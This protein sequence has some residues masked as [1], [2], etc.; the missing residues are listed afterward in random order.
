MCVCFGL[1]ERHRTEVCIMKRNHFDTQTAELYQSESQN[2]LMVGLGIVLV[3][4]MRR[5]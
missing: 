5:M 4:F 2:M 3:R 1:N